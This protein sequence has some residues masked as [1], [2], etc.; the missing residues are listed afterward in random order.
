[1]HIRNFEA[2]TLDEALREIKKQLG[3]DAIILKKNIQKL[4][5]I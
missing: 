3:P 4:L 1:M 5:L 2:D